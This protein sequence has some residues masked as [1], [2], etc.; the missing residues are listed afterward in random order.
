[1]LSQKVLRFIVSQGD[2]EP[3]FGSEWP[4]PP[5]EEFSQGC[6]FF[7]PGSVSAAFLHLGSVLQSSLNKLDSLFG[8]YS[9]V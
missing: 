9:S 5:E 2:L 4:G 3:R 7:S 8:S 1:M 6:L